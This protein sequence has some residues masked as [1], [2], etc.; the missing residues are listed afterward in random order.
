MEKKT[1]FSWGA[2]VLRIRCYLLDQAVFIIMISCILSKN[3]NVS[4][5]DEPVNLSQPTL[6][7]EIM[8]CLKLCIPISP[9]P[10]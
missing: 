2:K 1:I 5:C 10:V 8:Q 6:Y 4:P 7:E 3:E 9:R